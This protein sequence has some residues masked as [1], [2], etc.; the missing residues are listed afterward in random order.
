MAIQGI[1]QPGD[2]DNSARNMDINSMV[3]SLSIHRKAYPV[4]PQHQ[5]M[6]PVDKNAKFNFI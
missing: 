3:Q 6:Q 5:T 4:Q 1:H 2:Q